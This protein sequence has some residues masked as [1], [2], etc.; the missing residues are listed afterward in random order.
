MSMWA[1]VTLGVAL[2]IIGYTY[3]GYFVAI[4]LLARARP[5]PIARRPIRPRVSVILPAWRERATIADKLRTLAEGSYPAELLE[6]IVVCDG[7]DDGTPEAARAAGTP[8]FGERLRVIELPERRGKPTAL[9]AG[10]AAATGEILLLTDARQRLSANAISA[11]V[12]DLGDPS[13]GAVGGQLILDSGAP[14]GAY[15]RY[16]SL[17][18][19]LEGTAGSTVGV[20]GALYAMRRELFAPLPAETI[21]DDVLVPARVVLAGKR[22]GYEPEACAYD[23]SPPLDREFQRKARTLSGNFQ[24]LLLEPA[25][26]VPWR[27]PAWLGLVSHKLL[28]LIVP[29]LMIVC[30]LAAA[31]LPRPWGPLLVAAQ[32]AG[33][34]AAAAAALAPLKRVRLLGLCNTFVVLNAAAVVGLW[35]FIRYGRTLPW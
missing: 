26:L 14:T 20:S 22:V 17:L 34:L 15:W 11:L 32:L 10:V 31:G 28:R 33:Y 7:S 21:L 27:N 18:R 23:R 30:L 3:V 8:L 12:E 16:E 1:M 2:G 19:R 24:L 35:R 5:R 6:V 13:L 9:N 25:L 29:Y 4:W